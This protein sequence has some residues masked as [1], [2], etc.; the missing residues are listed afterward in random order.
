MH[1]LN[2]LEVEDGGLRKL[3]C[4]RSCIFMSESR[5]IVWA[6]MLWIRIRMFVGLPDLDR[7]VRGTARD[8]ALDPAIIKQK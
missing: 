6:G 1:Q 2:E 4:V 7:L 8:P 5:G 3:G